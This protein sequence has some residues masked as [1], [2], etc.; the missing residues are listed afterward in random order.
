MTGLLVLYPLSLVVV[1]ALRHIDDLHN[2][3]P[4]R[5]THFNTGIDKNLTLHPI[6]HQVVGEMGFDS[7]GQSRP[8]QVGCT[9][10][11]VLRGTYSVHVPSF[12]HVAHQSCCLAAQ[13]PEALVEIRALD[14]D[15]VSGV[16]RRALHRN[17]GIWVERRVGRITKEG[18]VEKWRMAGREWSVFAVV[19]VAEHLRLEDRA[20]EGMLEAFA[21][22]L[23]YEELRLGEI[24]DDFLEKLLRTY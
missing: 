13:V 19:R 21:D 14:L 20:G 15:P 16:S 5:W 12:P 10:G 18:I 6:L 9:A 1:V 3:E 23:Q 2:P 7:K 4:C 24:V 22:T 17:A 8:R 11:I